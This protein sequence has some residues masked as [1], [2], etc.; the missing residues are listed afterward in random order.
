MPSLFIIFHFIFMIIIADIIIIIIVD[1]D[2]VAAGIVI[3]GDVEISIFI[4][5]YCIFFISLY[6]S[7]H[8]LLV[9]APGKAWK[10]WRVSFIFDAVLIKRIK[11]SDIFINISNS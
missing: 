3:I 10:F 2:V 5:N 8:F 6:F 4:G 11:L 7:F 9:K 1:I